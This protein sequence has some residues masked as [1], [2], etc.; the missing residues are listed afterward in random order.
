[1]L[2]TAEFHDPRVPGITMIRAADVTCIEG[3]GEM[4]QQ[5]DLE[6]TLTLQNIYW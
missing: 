2:S 6:E 5:A 1:M 4:A 3:I